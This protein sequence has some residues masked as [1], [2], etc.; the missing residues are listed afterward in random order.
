MRRRRMKAQK[1]III[2]SALSLLLCFSIAYAAF[3]T[4]ISLKAKGNIKKVTSA[5]KLR[6]LVNNKSGD[7]L[8]ADV[9][10]NGR[11]FFKGADPNNYITFNGE[12]WR[13]LSVEYD[14]TIKIVKSSAL[15]ESMPWD[16][17]NNLDWSKSSLSKYLNETYF[18]S[19]LDRDSVVDHN[20]ASGALTLNSDY[21]NLNL[22]EQ[23][24]SEN[25]NYF[26]SK[27]GL[28]TTSEYLRANTN[29]DECGSLY[30]NNINYEK[31]RTTN[32]LSQTGVSDYTTMW[33]M[34]P[35]INNTNL[36][37]NEDNNDLNSTQDSNTVD[38]DS[39]NTSDNSVIAD[40]NEDQEDSNKLLLDNK[41]NYVFGISI[42]WMTSNFNEQKI[43]VGTVNAS[44]VKTNYGVVPVVYLNADVVLEGNGTKDDPYYIEK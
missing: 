21:S 29:S 13:I 15:E 26:N 23:I 38:D 37:N 33:T 14:D 40:E 44:D 12:E 41:Y 11:Y 31:C 5:S 42:P 17:E 4:Q 20:F 19:L 28:L 10:E 1:R 3:N 25:G 6:K 8:F 34:S 9:Y 43:P 30:L 39:S 18:N 36:T 16:T 22:N 27:V 7:G 24:L 32:Y 2:V 35:I